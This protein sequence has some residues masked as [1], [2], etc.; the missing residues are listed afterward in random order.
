LLHFQ[1]DDR[2]PRFAFLGRA[3]LLQS[4]T[5]QLR[6]LR[7]FQSA[8]VK[9]RFPMTE[10]ISP[11]ALALD[12]ASAPFLGQWKRLVST[13]NWEKGRI[14]QEWRQAL[15]A[16]GS[17]AAEYSDDAWSQRVGGVTGQHVGRLRRVYERFDALRAEFPALYWSHFQAALDW[18]DAEMWLEG[19]YQSGWSVAEMRLE[20]AETLSGLAGDAALADATANSPSN[21][22]SD[23]EP[24]DE[25]A[26]DGDPA[27]AA[28][29]PRGTR[30]SD[31]GSSGDSH[32]SA[33][34]AG[35]SA[36]DIPFVSDGSDG[37]TSPVEPRRPFA[38]LA[39]L[40]DDLGEPYEALKVAIIRHK[41]AGWKEVAIDDVIAAIDA[42]RELA[43]APA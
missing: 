31:V 13:T 2:R 37:E 24:L 21:D 40:P 16:A 5:G 27:A 36:D 23:V 15:V 22:A 7:H 9:A 8:N 43:L 41:F 1:V 19:A 39:E 6:R 32:R 38:H 4:W 18:D 3:A 29:I 17:P 33:P 42:L 30:L 20:R 26:G 25:D 11:A 12:E 10:T 34:P 14:I 28:T 35:S